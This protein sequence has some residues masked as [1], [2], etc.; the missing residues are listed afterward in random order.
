MVIFATKSLPD[1]FVEVIGHTI[2][3]TRLHLLLARGSLAQTNLLAGPHGTGKFL[4]AQHLANALLCEQRSS[5]GNACGS[6]PACKLI[7]AGSH[8]DLHSIDLG[9]DSQNSVEALRE[10]LSRLSLHAF[11]GGARVVILRDAELLNLQSANLL[12]KTLEEP[13]PNTYFLLTT[14]NA[15]KLPIT[16]RSRCQIWFL[17]RLSDQQVAEIVRCEL[18][19]RGDIESAADTAKLAAT[20]A[21]SEGSLQ[22]I[23]MLSGGDQSEHLELW[24]RI[25]TAL[26][27][28]MAGDLAA[29]TSFGASVAKSKE[30]LPLVISLMR[31]H[32]Q[33]RMHESPDVLE[34]RR[35]AIAVTNLIDSEYYLFERNLSAGYLLNF[36]FA[37]ICPASCSD[38]QIGLQH[39]GN[40]IGENAV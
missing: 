1:A 40:L 20:A 6:C 3:R 18:I 16:V 9:D 30:T 8:P 17:D 37:T 31:S 38:M 19:N 13:R 7:R 10:Y 36:I 28:C 29:G 5:S 27:R 23:D 35:W 4:V 34:K 11:R 21:L 2:Q 22:Y 12:L 15:S 32:C 39:G 14:A 33:A 26:D 25:T 24:K